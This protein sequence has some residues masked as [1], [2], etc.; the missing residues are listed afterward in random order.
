MNYEKA[1]KYA[2][3][4]HKDTPVRRGSGLEYITHPVA[5]AEMLRKKGFDN[6]IQ[7]M[8]LFHDL[9]EDTSATENEIIALSNQNAY[10]V[11]KL[12]TKEKDYSM[13]DY[14]SRIEK[15]YE[16]TAVK[17]AD[18]IHNLES[19]IVAD[20]EF[21]MKYYKESY[22][23]YKKLVEN[24][25]KDN[26]NIFLNDFNKAMSQL[27]NTIEKRVKVMGYGSLMNTVDFMRRFTTE[28]QN[29][30]IK[31][32]NGI[33]KGHK[34]AYT[35]NSIGREGGVLD[36]IKGN[37][38]DYVIGVVNEIPHH[39]M[40]RE[41]DAREGHPTLYKRELINVAI[42]GQKEIVYCYF[43]LEH[44]RNYNEITPH[45][46]Y[47]NIVLAGMVENS[48]PETYIKNY[49]KHVSQLNKTAE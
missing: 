45:D 41:L 14:M 27:N 15:S 6:N 10:D 32:G 7:I 13:D 42:N 46:D 12:L 9:L 31:I 22:E 25:S 26:R 5:V 24:S 49:K 8:G 3:K 29:S 17:L 30:I 40:V 23:Y 19:S 4:M 48:F 38:D 18:R 39:L 35:Y 44:R 28:E 20:E 16:A 37:E 36:V 21:R 1:L 2:T 33:L 47:H 34:L 43:V 11:V